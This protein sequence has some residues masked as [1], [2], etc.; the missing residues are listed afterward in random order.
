MQRSAT[1]S[2]EDVVLASPS[3]T[4]WIEAAAAD[5]LTLLDD[6]CQC[7]LKA[8]SN[9]LA[10]VGRHPRHDGLVQALTALAHE[11]LR[12]YRQ[13][14]DELRSRSRKPSPPMRS[15][16]LAGLNGQRRPGVERLLDELLVAS[17]VEARSCERFER[18]AEA[19]EATDPTLAALYE[20]LIR[21]ERGHAGLFLRLADELFPPETVRAELRRRV[22]LES[23]L[24]DALPTT[25]R[26]HGGHA[27]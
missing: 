9:A 5:P 11:E 17:L 10:L 4:R 18:L 27:G 6:H 22:P 2:S 21:A 20:G 16:Y 12:H 19:F 14:R 15:P 3:H 24:L 7:E 23:E 8:A 26:M 13:V 25:A 1:A